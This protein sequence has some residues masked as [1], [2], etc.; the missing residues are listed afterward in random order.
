MLR[1]KWLADPQP[2][3]GPTKEARGAWSWFS[4]DARPASEVLYMLLAIH[5][6]WRLGLM[7]IGSALGLHAR[8]QWTFKKVRTGFTVD[9]LRTRY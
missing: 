7:G 8:V 3:L 4:I 5:A 2:L 6:E 9:I 1:Y